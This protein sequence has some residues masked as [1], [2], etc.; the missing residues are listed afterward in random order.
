MKWVWLK[1]LKRDTHAMPLA[2]RTKNGPRKHV[3]GFLAMAE[4]PRLDYLDD[5]K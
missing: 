1:C 3:I 2:C 5:V 4:Q